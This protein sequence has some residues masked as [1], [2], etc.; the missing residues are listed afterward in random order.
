MPCVHLRVTLN[1]LLPDCRLRSFLEEVPRILILAL[2]KEMNLIIVKDADLL[3]GSLLLSKE[4][5]VTDQVPQ[6]GLALWRV[7]GDC[8]RTDGG[9]SMFLGRVTE[10]IFLC[11]LLMGAFG[12]LSTHERLLRKHAL[13]AQLVPVLLEDHC[14]IGGILA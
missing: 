13:I 7:N 5:F 4:V 3:G 6:R 8:R 14:F 2:L 12:I 10:Q 1:E 11:T 9:T